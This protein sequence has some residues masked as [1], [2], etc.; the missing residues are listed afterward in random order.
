MA[1]F[2]SSV[3]VRHGAICQRP[4]V[5]ARPVTIA[6]FVGGRLASGTRSWM[7]WLPGHDAA[8]QM[9]DT[10]VVRVHQHGACIADNSHQDMGRSRGGLT[11]KI[12]AVVDT[13]GLPVHLALTPG[14][15]HDNRLCS[16]LLSA[17]LP[18]TML[19][20]D[21]GYDADWIREFA[22]QQGAWGTFRRNEIA[23]TDLLQPVSLSCAELDRT[24]LQQDQAMSARRDP[25]QQTRSQLSGVHQARI[26]PNLARPRQ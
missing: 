4:M 16:V 25:V 6:S 1:S 18:Q 17:L 3:R 19:L 2:G 7:R 15:A 26:N 22:R 23:K 20:A 9:I 24:V 12:H 5:P 10:S 8:V 21:R 11:S 13:N 14:E